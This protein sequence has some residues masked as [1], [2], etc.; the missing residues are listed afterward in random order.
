MYSILNGFGTLLSSFRTLGGPENMRFSAG[1]PY[2]PESMNIDSAKSAE[3]DVHGFWISRFADHIEDARQ[4]GFRNDEERKYAEGRI[5]LRRPGGWCSAFTGMTVVCRS[6][7]AAFVLIAAP[8]AVHAQAVDTSAEH[9]IMIE[10]DTGDIL[11]SKE[12]DA[13]IPPASMAKMMTVYI[14]FEQ[15]AEGS[16]SLED[17]TVVSEQAWK[18]WA[19]SEGSLMFLGVNEEVSV[20]DLLMGIVVSSGNDACT[21]LAEMLAG[22]EE[23]FAMWM[24]EKA[25]ELGME[26]SHFENASGWPHPDQH[27]TV[28]DLARLA[29]A[30]VRDFPELYTEYYPKK[31]FTYGKDF[32][33]GDPITQSNRNPLL[34]RMDGADGLKTGHTEAAGYGLAA[35]AERDGRRLVLVIAGLGS[36]AARARES[37]SVLEYGFRAFDTYTLFEAGEAVGEADVWLGSV[38]KLPLVVDET[39]KLTLSRRT[40]A[41]LKMVLS[42]D[43]PVPAPIAQGTPVATVEVSAPDMEPLSIPV[44]AGAPVE[45]VGGFGRIGAALQYLLFGSAAE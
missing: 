3:A 24:N 32:R 23:A 27:T 26:N 5:P 17:T 13:R 28:R 15:I 12:P 25:A 7:F 14:A 34:Y 20:H 38:P 1:E 40:R 35:S 37:Q 29:E 2:D 16:L 41:G 21:V 44:V 36:Q 18:R 4:T 10:L 45:Q 31:S 43:N 33:T 6:I 19:G 9:A 39:I 8:A 22:T 42:Y 11:F 30:T